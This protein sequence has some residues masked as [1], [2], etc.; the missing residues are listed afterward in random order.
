MKCKAGMQTCR[1]RKGELQAL[2]LRAVS[3]PP[4][5]PPPPPPP[6]GTSDSTSAS[7]VTTRCQF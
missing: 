7:N 2:A 5:P 4:Q 6:A 3:P 1:K